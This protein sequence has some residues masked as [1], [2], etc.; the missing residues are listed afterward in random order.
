MEFKPLTRAFA[1]T[2]ASRARADRAYRNELLREALL[3]LIRGELRTA[4]ATLRDYLSAAL[5]RRA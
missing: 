1:E 2:V 4:R 5:S 3:C